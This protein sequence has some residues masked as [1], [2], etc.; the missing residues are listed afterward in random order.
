M[1]FSPSTASPS[2]APAARVRHPASVVQVR[3]RSLTERLLAGNAWLIFL[4]FY[5]PIVVLVI[6]SFNSGRFVSRWEGFSLAWYAKLF[7]N[8]AIALAL[9]NSLIVAFA[10]TI[11][12]TILATLVAVGLE[13]YRFRGKTAL[14][15]VLYLPI[16]IPDI[17]MAVML[18]LFF[19]QAGQI[20]GKIGMGFSL[21]LGTVIL[22][23][24]AFNISF[25]TVTVRARLADF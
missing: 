7:Q 3:R 1:T 25:V 10:S 14:D 13:R 12:S 6:F 17:A 21:G 9:R 20:L 16:I 22:A 18:L 23:H 15:S 24:I 19:I 5:A 11:V 8:Q 2:T 4:F